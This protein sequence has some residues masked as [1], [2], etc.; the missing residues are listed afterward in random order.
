ME[1]QPELLHLVFFPFL[2]RSHMIPMLET[3]RLAVERGV[4]T[5]LVT[6]PANAHLIHPVL[7]RSNSSLLPSHPPMQLQLIPF[8]SVEFGIPEGCENLTSIPL[9]LVAAFF[10]AIFALRAPLG[11]LLRELGAHALVADALFPWA[12]GLAAE[13][14]IP[15][16]IFQVMG[17]FPL[18]GAHDLDTHRPHE[19]V[20]GD[21]EEFTIPGFPD[22]VK[23]T[24]GQ[25]PEVFRHD[26][27]LAL[28]RDAEFTSYGVIVNSFYALE[29]SYAE[30]YYKVAPRKVFLLGP[31]ALAG[32]NP[33]PLPLESGDPCI[34]WLDS[35]PDNS[36]LYLSF[37]TTCRFS[38][39]QLVELAEGLA[40]SGHNF[41]W[42][43]ALPESSGSTSEEWLPEGYERNVAGRGLLV[44]GWAPQTAILNHR[45][46]GGFVSQCGWNAVMEAVAAEVP[47]I[48]WPLHS[49]HFIT[50]KLF[51][52]VLHVAVPMWEGR[53]SIWDDQKE[54]VRAKTVAASVKWLMGGGDEIEAMRRRVRE[55][56][57]L[58]RAAV[59]EGGSSHSDMGRLIDVLTEERNKAKE[60]IDK[61]SVSYDCSGRN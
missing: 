33:S 43:V 2:A 47:M 12:T 28:L 40:S 57:E 17:L 39:E 49:D 20:G 13:M 26:F 8:P 38:D 10:K 4:K 5:T 50:E 21:D 29:P 11:A 31:V 18:C 54:V 60:M 42:V 44:N 32:S 1:S 45:A 14:G 7:H 23:L 30:H 61:N 36:V 53:K 25:V 58:G 35:K 46:V 41:V 34:T 56:G 27:M 19:A 9:P 3:A 15:R 59:A 6:T 48:T 37:G 51:C 16:L 22:P 24:R 55:L 52:D